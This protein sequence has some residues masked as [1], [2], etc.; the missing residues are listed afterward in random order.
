MSDTDYARGIIFDNRS[1]MKLMRQNGKTN[2]SL[3][4]LKYFEEVGLMGTDELDLKKLETLI[5]FAD[6]MA[7]TLLEHDGL[8]DNL[9]DGENLAIEYFEFR[10]VADDNRGTA[11]TPDVQ[12]MPIFESAEQADS[13]MPTLAE[14]HNGVRW[15]LPDSEGS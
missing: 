14:I 2:L 12:Q 9:R 10:G 7:L 4:Y 11:E 13:T 3:Q 8:Q 6:R 5:I 15:V 1:P